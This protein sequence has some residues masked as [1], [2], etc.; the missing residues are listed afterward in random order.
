MPGLVQRCRTRASADEKGSEQ[1]LAGL[2]QV[3]QPFDETHSP[4]LLAGEKPGS[5]SGIR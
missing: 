1:R 4:G 2:C 5:R 3:S